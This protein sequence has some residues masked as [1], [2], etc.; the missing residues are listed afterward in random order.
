M[1]GRPAVDVRRVQ[2]LKDQGLRNAQIAA[3]LGITKSSVS[4]VL[5]KVKK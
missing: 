1:P 3:R 2:Q 5:G 4:R